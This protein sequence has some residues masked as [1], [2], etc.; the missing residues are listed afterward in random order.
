[1]SLRDASGWQTGAAA[2]VGGACR[3]SYH[4]ASHDR[5]PRFAPIRLADSEGNARSVQG[6]GAENGNPLINGGQRMLSFATVFPE[7]ARHIA[8]AA[9]TPFAKT[10][11]LELRRTSERGT[12]YFERGMNRLG[13]LA[14]RSE[15]RTHNPLVEGSN[16]SGPT[17]QA[18]WSLLHQSLFRLLAEL[19]RST[20]S[21]AS[22]HMF[23]APRSRLVTV[24][25][26]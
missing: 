17:T 1:M 20:D 21:Q 5:A 23:S 26:A 25:I 4:T 3:H 18:A 9:L 13:P 7:R 11:C 22:A 12:C 6:L 16:P 14:Q 19:L 8:R 2:R 24:Q 10:D 15:Q